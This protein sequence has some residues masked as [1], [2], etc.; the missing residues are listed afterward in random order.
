MKDFNAVIFDMDGVIIDSERLLMSFW[1]EVGEKYHFDHAEESFCKT[2]GLNIRKTRESFLEDYGPDFPFDRYDHE[3][4]EMFFDAY[5]Q[6]KLP[7]KKGAMELLQALKKA[8]K[9]TALATSTDFK[10]VKKELTD[11]GVFQYFDRVIAGD[12]VTKGKPD[13][14]IYSKACQALGEKPENCYAVEDAYN[15]ILSAKNCGARVVMVPDL[16]PETEEISGMIECACD[17]LEKFGQYLGIFEK[18]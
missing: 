14:E 6:G 1:V 11:L 18:E 10:Y 7:L 8:G 5:L 2:L 17:S 3:V 15:G 4:G 13:P 12:M 9:K 16:A